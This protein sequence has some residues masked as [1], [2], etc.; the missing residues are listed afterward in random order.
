MHR[1][2]FSEYGRLLHAVWH[3]MHAFSRA[4]SLTALLLPLLLLLLLLQGR[5]PAA[6]HSLPVLTSRLR[7]ELPGRQ[8]TR[9]L[10][11][12]PHMLQSDLSMCLQPVVVSA[13]S[14]T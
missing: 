8:L 12:K 10:T 13:N 14:V 4:V 6:L 1:L 7:N 11:G 2:V 5:Q 9:Q 3:A